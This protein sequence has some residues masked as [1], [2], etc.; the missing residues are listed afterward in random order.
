M[1]K[2][3]LPKAAENIIGIEVKCNFRGHGHRCRKN[4]R[5][6]EVGQEVA[7]RWLKTWLLF[8]HKANDQLEHLVIPMTDY[9]DLLSTDALEIETFV[10]EETAGPKR[11]RLS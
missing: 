1:Y 6:G 9:S 10:G 5:F 7:E 11:I 3:G 4:H 8:A 2:R